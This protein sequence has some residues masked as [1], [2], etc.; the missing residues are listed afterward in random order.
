MFKN[1]ILGMIAALTLVSAVGADIARAQDPV[2][3]RVNGKELLEGDLKLAEAEI[4]SDLGSLAGV[5]RRRV[6]AEFLIETQLFA[7]AAEAQKLPLPT[8]TQ[9]TPYWKRRALRDAYFEKVISKSVEEGD[10]KS[11]YDEHIG[12]RKPED[13]VRARHILV[14]TKE[15]AQEIF[16]KL[17]EGSDFVALA[18]ENTTDPGSKDQGGDLGF[19]VRGQ[20]IPPFEEAAFSL[21][22]GQFSEPIQTQFGWHIVKVEARREREIPPFVTVKDRLTAAVIHRKAQLI[23]MNLRSKSKIEY[24]DADIKKLVETEQAQ[25]KN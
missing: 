21:R 10:V 8:N 2:A 4:G 12:T 24:V 1:S 16:A 7:D 3:V 9:D 20:M 23:V 6:L 18:K 25:Q 17:K 13:E 15:K 22:P 5:P 14:E 19:F 11:F